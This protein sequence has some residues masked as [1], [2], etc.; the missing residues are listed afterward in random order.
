MNQILL[1]ACTAA[2]NP[3]LLTATTVML[4]LDNPKRLLL[5]YLCGAYL[6]SITLGLLIVFELDGS[7]SATSTAQNT[8]SPVVDIVFGVLFL[9]IA[10]VVGTGRDT[11]RRARSAKRKAA[12]ADKAPPKWQQKL[13]TGTARTTFVIGALLTLPGG[14]YLAGL[15][16]ISK[17]DFSNTTTVLVIIGFNVI[18]L[19]LLEV[20]L[21]GYTL[22]PEKT[23]RT[24]ERVKAWLSRR[25][26]RVGII[27]A[28]VV[29]V[30]LVVKG[31]A[32]LV[33]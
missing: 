7:S 26:G 10:F 5:G 16:E 20:P 32:Q 19:A 2:F 3:T 14:S 8:V 29:G 1:V 24:V 6:T 28:V 4:L 22:S 33:T 23:A 12:K 15:D 30:L 25:G 11:R 18:M 17:Q 27:V 21:I 13:S 31:V 9:V